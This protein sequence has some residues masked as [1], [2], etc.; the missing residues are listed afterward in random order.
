MSYPYYL[1]I[2]WSAPTNHQWQLER[3]VCAGGGRDTGSSLSLPPRIL[4]SQIMTIARNLDWA[5]LNICAYKPKR[6]IFIGYFTFHVIQYYSILK[7]IMYALLYIRAIR[8]L[9]SKEK[10]DRNLNL[11]LWFSSWNAIKTDSSMQWCT[12]RLNDKF[13]IHSYNYWKG[14]KKAID[15]VTLL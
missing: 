3:I 12:I 9:I 8:F 5:K 4:W 15:C 1:P 7:S 2:V 6:L 11:W 10:V 13:T 14:E